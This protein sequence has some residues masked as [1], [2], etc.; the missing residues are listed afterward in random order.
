MDDGS[1]RSIEENMHAKPYFSM[2][3]EFSVQ[4]VGDIV[5]NMTSSDYE[6]EIDSS[7]DFFGNRH[8]TI[9]TTAC[10]PWM[11]GTAVNPTL[12]AAYL[13]RRQIQ[14]KGFS[15][16]TGIRLVVPWLTESEDR[17]RLYGR[18]FLCEKE[19]ELMIR[20]WLA[21]SAGMEDAAAEE[22]GIE[23]VFYPAFY[24]QS[25]GSILPSSDILSLLP[26]PYDVCVLEEPEHLNWLRPEAGSMKSPDSTSPGAVVSSPISG[27]SYPATFK[28]VIGIIHTNYVAY[29][30]DLGWTG[31]FA[32]FSLGVLNRLVVRA[33]CHKIIKLSAVLQ[34]FFLPK[35][36]REVVCNVHGVREEFLKRGKQRA[37]AAREEEGPIRPPPL[38]QSGSDESSCIP[39][40]YFIGKLLWAKGL[41]RLLVLQEAHRRHLGTYFAMDI[42]GSGPDE[43]SIRKAFWGKNRNLLEGNDW[44]GTANV[45]EEESV[46]EHYRNQGSEEW[47]GEFRSN[48]PDPE[49][50][51]NS[52]FSLRELA[53]HIASDGEDEVRK[54]LEVN[55]SSPES[56]VHLA[57]ST[58]NV[59]ADLAGGAIDTC[60]AASVAICKFPTLALDKHAHHA[61]RRA[62]IPVRFLGRMD[63]ATITDDY[64]IFVNPSV[65]EV[66][67]TT[68]AESLAMGNFVVIPLHVSN[69]FFYPFPNCLTYAGP[70]EFIEKLQYALSNNPVPIDTKMGHDLS[71]EAAIDRL[72]EAASMSNEEFQ[73]IRESREGVIDERIASYHRGLWTQNNVVGPTV[74]SF[75][76]G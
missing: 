25:L 14:M 53:S 34:D 20:L 50:V 67:C 43:E 58:L 30:K 35:N 38:P 39:L 21:E 72:V 5:S 59:T 24:N 29:A 22:G 2:N 48:L 73:G 69:E 12:R 68:T 8:V 4:H 28:F 60:T 33:Y 26:P 9:I 27:S 31:T 19:Q 74:Q 6:G 66:L 16:G 46:V 75:L 64:R 7:S 41:D 62:P 70:E 56:E 32:G 40:V 13:R 51:L 65:S 55:Q 71:W 76:G 23:I 54:G 36:G 63:H 15:D 57:K 3:A 61:F 37:V 18:D 47:I 45:D 17:Q 11:T 49:E 42:I 10:F 1:I 44:V 52:L